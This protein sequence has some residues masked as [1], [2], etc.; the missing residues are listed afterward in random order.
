[1]LVCTGTGLDTDLFV[2]G[3]PLKI[4]FD[5]GCEAVREEVIENGW[6]HHYALMYGDHVDELKALCRNLD[7]ELHL[8]R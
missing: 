5:A 3:N 8:V 2:R 1:M 7:I 6:E 4:K